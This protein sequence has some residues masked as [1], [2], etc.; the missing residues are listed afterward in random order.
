MELLK[1][2]TQT[3][4]I[5]KN[6]T[7]SYLVPAL[8]YYGPIFKT[9]MSSL[10]TKAFGIGDNDLKD[11][12]H[13]NNRKSIFILYDTSVRDRVTESIIDWFKNQEYYVDNI[14][15]KSVNDPYYILI[16]DFPQHM[17]D[18]YDKFLEGK[19]SKM[20][21][22]NEVIKYFHVNSHAK[23]ISVLK[24]TKPGAINHIAKIK[25]DYNVIL[26]ESDLIKEN[27]EYDYPFN[28][29]EEIFNY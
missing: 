18:A 22:D 24:K 20:Y 28:P 8:G 4:K 26:T 12:P 29:K 3:G 6:R 2:A 14:P 7:L 10:P 21:A 23:A 27:H 5:V 25:E 19:Y 1:T 15:F 17:E 16:I 13:L 11:V 9:K